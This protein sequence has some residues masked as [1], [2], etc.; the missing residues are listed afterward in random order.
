MSVT[1][2]SQDPRAALHFFVQEIA[3]QRWHT[4]LGCVGKAEA[5]ACAAELGPAKLDK[6]GYYLRGRLGRQYR[7][8]DVNGRIQNG[9]DL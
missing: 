8:V 4:L 1:Y 2:E 3:G 5:F 9:A 6:D 7:V